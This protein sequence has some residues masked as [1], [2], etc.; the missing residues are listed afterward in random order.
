VSKLRNLNVSDEAIVAA[1]QE[2]LSA[3]KVAEVLNIS[4]K[5]V[6]R[7]LGKSGI[8]ATGLQHYRKNAE[9]HSR[10]TQMEIARLY[11][12]GARTPDLMK[13]FGGGEYAIRHA[14]LRSGGTMRPSGGQRPRKF[15]N[16]D[17][18]AEVLKLHEAGLTQTAISGVLE[19]SQGTVSRVLRDAGI[20]STRKQ[21]NGGRMKAEKYVRVQVSSDDPFSVMRDRNG[22]VLEH[23]IIMARALGRPLQDSETVH[24]INGDHA[25]NRIEN[26]Q[27]RQGKHG[28]GIVM[29]C[30]DC[31]SHRVGPVEIAE[32]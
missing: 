29:C 30:L 23:R 24:H 15:L 3:Y 21:R 25:D 17:E 27:L 19:T 7:V 31:G 22:Y 11:A 1:Y 18:I 12:E 14:I 6:Y 8:K 13:K 2:Y 28:K 10:E 20:S 32:E 5:R 4:D 9:G 26:L 16:V